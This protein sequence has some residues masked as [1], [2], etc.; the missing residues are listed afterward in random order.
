MNKYI[1]MLVCVGLVSVTGIVPALAAALTFGQGVDGVNPRKNTQ[2]ATKEN[3]VK[4]K[5][6]EVRWSGVV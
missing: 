4:A 5:G 3:W 2:L 1:S 6:Q